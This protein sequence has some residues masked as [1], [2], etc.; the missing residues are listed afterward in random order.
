MSLSGLLQFKFCFETVTVDQNSLKYFMHT[1]GDLFLKEFVESVELL[2]LLRIGKLTRIKRNQFRKK[3]R[4]Y[5]TNKMAKMEMEMRG[6]SLISEI[7]HK[8]YRVKYK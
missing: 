1:W 3:T 7:Y 5:Q 8:W 6:P 2:K 4:M